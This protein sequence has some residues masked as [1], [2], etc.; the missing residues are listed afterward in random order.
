MN[1]SLILMSKLLSMMIIAGVGFVVLRM[2]V[3]EERDRKQLA[4]LTLYVLQPSLIVLAF[5]ID[6]TPERLKGFLL[7]VVFSGIVQVGFI[8]VSGILRRAGLLGVIE[9][10]SVIYVNCGNL[11]LPIVGMT[12]GQE[13]VFY[14]SAFPLTF[15]LLFWAHG[16]SCIEG[17]RRIAWKKILLNSNIIAL[18]IGLFLLLTGIPI[19][20]AVRT[21]MQLMADMV[22]PCAML[23][24]GMTLAGSSVRTVLT[25]QKGYLVSALRLLV[26]PFF[27]LGILYASGFLTRHPEY[28]PVLRVSFMGVAAPPASNVAQIAVLYDRDPVHAGIYNLLGMLFCVLTIPLIDYVY[29]QMFVLP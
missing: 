1:T 25:F 19:P 26:F 13:M 22:G 3:L 21:S 8:L 14:A 18:L 10:L 6:L 2:G 15:N 28:I 29:A 4:K 16:I 7:A 5:Q 24:V 17:T 20:G 12:M 23:V 11:I 27:T 9:E